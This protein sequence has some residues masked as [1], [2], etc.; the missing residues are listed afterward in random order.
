MFERRHRLKF[1][2]LESAVVKWSHDRGLIEGTTAHHQMVKLQEE[3]GELAGA[4]L[5]G[6]R[7]KMVDGVGDAIVVLINITEKL[8]LGGIEW[9]LE[10]AYDE[11]KDRRGRMIDG[12][13][14]KES[15]LKDKTVGEV[16]AW[17]CGRRD[18]VMLCKRCESH[19]MS[20]G[21]CDGLCEACR[22]FYLNECEEGRYETGA[23]F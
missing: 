12:T 5:K 23:D 11:I 8:K 21:C 4:I 19:V 17:Q 10:M 3:L 15:D 1:D 18:P 7:A 16:Y 2:E 20:P 14:V 6:D 9:C 22:E 13:F